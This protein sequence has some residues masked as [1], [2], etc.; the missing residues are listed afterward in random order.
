MDWMNVQHTFCDMRDLSDRIDSVG[1][2]VFDLRNE[3]ISEIMLLV[4][5]NGKTHGK[6]VILSLSSGARDII[7][8]PDVLCCDNR[9]TDSY[10]FADIDSISVSL[11]N[12]KGVGNLYFNT[13]Y[14]SVSARWAN[15]NELIDIYDSLYR[16]GELTDELDI[17][18]GVISEKI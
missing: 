2:E 4:G 8:M 16:I 9:H 12:G 17:S 14:D 1:K 11:D 3:I 5:A 15:I 13:E 7:A 18:D 10:C 6:E